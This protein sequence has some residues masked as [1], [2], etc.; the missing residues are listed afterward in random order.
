MFSIKVLVILISLSI[1]C[2]CEFTYDGELSKDVI[3]HENEMNPSMTNEVIAHS[4]AIFEKGTSNY[5]SIAK[6]LSTHLG[7][8]YNGTWFTMIGDDKFGMSDTIKHK[9]GFYIKFSYKTHLIIVMET[10]NNGDNETFNSE[11]ELILYARQY[12]DKAEKIAQSVAF[13][14]GTYFKP[15]LL[16]SKSMNQLQTQIHEYAKVNSPAASNVVIVGTNNLYNEISGSINHT[17]TRQYYFVR[18][19]GKL[20]VSMWFYNK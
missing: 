16:N 15:F 20:Y 18:Y 6:E 19:G 11:Y 4:A 17:S 7:N 14:I 2:N 8:V 1:L 9:H 12:A 10:I 13:D 3:I 5:S